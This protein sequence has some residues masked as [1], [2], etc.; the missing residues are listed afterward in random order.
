M[1]KIISILLSTC[2]VF[3][4]LSSC[5]DDKE[6]FADKEG[7]SLVIIIGR[8][9]NSK[10]FMTD[11]EVCQSIKNLC[12]DCFSYSHDQRYIAQGNISIIVCDGNPEVIPLIDEDGK[13]ISLTIKRNTPQNRET[14]VNEAIDKLIKFLQSD[15]TKANDP[16]VDLLSALFD[17]QF[18]LDRSNA[19]SKEILI[20]DSGISTT[21]AF[22]M[23]ANRIQNN[24]TDDIISRIP[25]D[26]IP[27]LSGVKISFVGLA[28]VA[29]PQTLP[30]PVTNKLKRIWTDL[31]EN[32]CGATLKSEIKPYQNPGENMSWYEDG[33]GYPRVTTVP[34]FDELNEEGVIPLSSSALGFKPG[35][36][37]FYDQKQA[38][39]VIET[40]AGSLKT[41]F[42]GD[43]DAKI[44]VVGSIAKT[45][46]N[47]KPKR[48]SDVSKKRA[49][50]VAN[51]LKKKFGIPDKQIV[52]IDAGSIKFSWRNAIEFPN[53]VKNKTNMQ[54]NR[55][56]AVIPATSTSEVKELREA[57][58]ID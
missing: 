4:L 13:E 39:Y 44:Y 51:I 26:Y 3:T 17:A 55:L 56:V 21:G 25:E 14:K 50:K 18:I 27:I 43:P 23:N 46:K 2:L 20:L 48:S 22:N 5:G 12:Y 57:D 41:Y 36:D 42:T 7:S 11:P 52:V 32:R 30:D 8:H 1:K 35:S 34:F 6:K 54:K 19:E 15:A 58:F 24:N 40:M 38:E 29:E 10:D 53:G 47:E 45:S 28:N 49:K 9:A 33:G 31:L 16:E 37:E